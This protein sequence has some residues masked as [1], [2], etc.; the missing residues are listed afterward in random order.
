MQHNGETRK[1]FHNDDIIIV[2][3]GGNRIRPL[4]PGE[5]DKLEYWIQDNI[6]LFRNPTEA[7]RVLQRR[8]NIADSSDINFLT[9][10]YE[11]NLPVIANIS[12]K[13]DEIQCKETTPQIL[14]TGYP[15][16]YA[17][18]AY[19]GAE[20]YLESMGKLDSEVL[21][22]LDEKSLKE[23][24]ESLVR[25]HDYADVYNPVGLPIDTYTIHKPET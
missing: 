7:A 12:V 15:D 22:K 23:M 2:T 18:F 3:H 6:E 16:E 10:R 17:Y 8:R 21:S 1:L 9:G 24:I 19:G 20:E 13:P 14:Q 11:G 25:Y 5:P 4:T